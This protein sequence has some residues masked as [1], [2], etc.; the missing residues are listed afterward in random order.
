MMQALLAFAAV[1]TMA[2]GA[3]ADTVWKIK[4]ATPASDDGRHLSISWTRN[5]GAGGLVVVLRRPVVDGEVPKAEVG[6]ITA[7]DAIFQPAFLYPAGVPDGQPKF[8]DASITPMPA[9]STLGVWTIVAIAQG[10]PAEPIVD[11]VPFGGRYVYAFVPATPGAE[12]DT[13]LS[14]GAA[15][16]TI[17]VEPEAAWFDAKRWFHLALIVLVAASLFGFTWLARRR[18]LFI[19]RIPGVDAIEDAVGRS[20]EMGRPILYVTGVERTEDIQTIAS[21]LILGHV[22]EIA[23]TYETDLRVA[24]AFPLTMVL[25]E[26]VVRQGYANAGRPDAHRPEDVMF[27]TSEQFAFAA[28]VNGIMVRERPATTIYFGRFYAESLILAETGF[29]TGAVQIAGT[30]ELTQLPF[31]I[32]ACDYTLIGEE[33]FACSAYLTQEPTQ[34]AMLKAGDVM[35]VVIAILVV[36][37]TAMATIDGLGYEVPFLASDLL[38]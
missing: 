24:N 37:C 21:I 19:R 20:T 31:F 23:A 7:R 34:I 10:D 15:A 13:Y 25:A 1:C 5:A 12:P 30:A 32:S 17:A 3:G 2:A 26:E 18:K 33:L 27:V 4:V 11:E 14:F 6:S 22:A 16:T 28:A 35:K 8:F 36:A 38:P 9:K 29:L